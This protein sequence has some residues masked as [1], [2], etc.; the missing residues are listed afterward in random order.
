MQLILECEYLYDKVGTYVAFSADVRKFLS[1]FCRVLT[2][3]DEMFVFSRTTWKYSD[4]LKVSQSNFIYAQKLDGRKVSHFL[5]TIQ[6]S[7]KLIIN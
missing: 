1:C 2:R 6:K 3:S 4:E 7:F 5:I